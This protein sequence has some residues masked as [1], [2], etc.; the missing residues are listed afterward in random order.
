MSTLITGAFN[1]PLSSND[2]CRPKPASTC[3]SVTYISNISVD[4]LSTKFPSDFDID[5]TPGERHGFISKHLSQDV[6]L[7]ARISKVNFCFKTTFILGNCLTD[8]FICHSKASC[9]NQMC[10]LL[11]GKRHWFQY[12]LLGEHSPLWATMGS[13]LPSFEKVHVS[14]FTLPAWILCCFL[15]LQNVRSAY[16]HY[17]KFVSPKY[18]KWIFMTLM[19]HGNRS[20]ET[21]H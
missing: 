21:R 10:G 20:E 16:P 5:I 2:L 11:F 1:K 14:P 9:L 6:T 13:D 4:K 18:K 19:W 17:N 12:D 3:L 7:I 8:S 15:F